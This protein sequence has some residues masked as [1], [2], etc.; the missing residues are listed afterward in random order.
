[1]G[2]SASKSIDIPD[3]VPAGPLRDWLTWLQ[4]LR[5]RAN[6][7]SLTEI[8]KMTLAREHPVSESTV[9]RLL[10]GECLS[11]PSA[12]AVAYAL[13]AM[14]TRP[15]PGKPSDD[16]EAFDRDLIRCYGAAASGVVSGTAETSVEASPDRASRLLFPT[17]RRGEA[18]VGGPTWHQAAEAISASRARHTPTEEMS[19]AE[20]LYA[21]EKVKAAPG[22][23]N[24]R[25]ARQCL[26]R[27]KE[28]AWLTSTLTG[29]QDRAT[30]PTVIVTG[31]GGIGKTTLVSEYARLHRRKYT[32][33]WWVNAA[34]SD[35]IETSLAHLTG[36]LA[37][38]QLKDAGRTAQVNWAMQ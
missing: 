13:A 8:S 4:K 21:A 34:S 28:L 19:T 27:E 22:T 5:R 11:D 14:D 3:S 1:M 2:G 37:P 36:R 18:D 38:G 25:P 33:V 32:L 6:T 20:S 30:P 24:L 15:G 10:R 35:E 23:S 16:W 31:L 17:F 9:R 7:P 12:Y 29:R 26:G